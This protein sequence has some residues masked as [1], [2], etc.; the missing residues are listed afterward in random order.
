MLDGLDKAAYW[1]GDRK[2]KINFLL[3]DAPTHG[4][5]KFHN[6]SS[7]IF[8]RNDDFPEGFP[9]GLIEFDIKVDNKGIRFKSWIW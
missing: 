7:G 1:I 9:C 4:K 6:Y 8:N 2:A 5:G 3:A